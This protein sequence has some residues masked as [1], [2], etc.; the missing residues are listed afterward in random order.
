MAPSQ[1]MMPADLIEGLD[2]VSNVW[3][4]EPRLAYASA[5]S[6]RGDPMR[7]GFLP[8]LAVTTA[9]ASAGCSKPEETVK[10]AVAS[11]VINGALAKN[12][13]HIDMDKTMDAMKAMQEQAKAPKRDVVSFQ[14]L[15]PLL[16]EAPAGWTAQ[17]V[18]G[19]TVSMGAYKVSEAT[20]RYNKGPA[21]ITVTITDM[22]QN[23]AAAMV[24]MAF[25]I[26]EEST[27]GYRK[28]FTVAGAQGSEQWQK[29]NKHSEITAYTT[30]Q[31]L[32][33][34]AGGG[35]ESPDA[36]KDLF[37]K[38]DIAKLSSLKP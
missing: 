36:A 11:A 19:H 22:A 33:Q 10:A 5:F 23:P 14:K 4:N 6:F 13:Q 17:P 34:A 27:D 12:G 7:L 28:P 3:T 24:A 1:A 31:I 25:S 20:R 8:I 35:L 32:V 30:N 18:D 26:T 21:Q 37:G 38:I 2:E 29:G 9:L 16:P 15:T